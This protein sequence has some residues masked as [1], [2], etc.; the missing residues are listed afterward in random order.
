MS[1]AYNP[2]EYDNEPVVFCSKCYSLKIKHDETTDSDYCEACGCTEIKSA[3]IY[4]WEKMYER[5][6]GHKY[7]VKNNDPRKSAVFKMSVEELK[8]AVYTH[9]LMDDIVKTLYPRFPGGLTNEER[10]VMLFDKLFKDNRLD[11]L[12]YLLLHYS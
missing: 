6:F 10:V 7:V 3:N 11:D 5:R 8:K 1:K 2:T 4:V 12:R 9:P